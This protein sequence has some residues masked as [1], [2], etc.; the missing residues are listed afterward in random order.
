MEYESVVTGNDENEGERGG[1]RYQDLIDR[2][3][4]RF[5]AI[6]ERFT[7]MNT[8]LETI[9]N[10]QNILVENGAAIRDLEPTPEVEDDTIPDFWD[11]DLKVN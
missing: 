10:A 11:F 7:Q 8:L 9:S 5:E 4:T 6:E 3:T 1:A 2:F